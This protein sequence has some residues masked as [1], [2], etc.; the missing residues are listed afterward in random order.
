MH[1]LQ[2]LSFMSFVLA[3]DLSC[4]R[5]SI[6]VLSMAAGRGSWQ[7]ADNKKRSDCSLRSR[8]CWRDSLALR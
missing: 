4:D 7:P 2:G 1:S 6:A 3:F 5:S 8:V